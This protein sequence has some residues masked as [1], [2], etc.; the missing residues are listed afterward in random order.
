MRCGFRPRDRDRT[1]ERREVAVKSWRLTIGWSDMADEM[2]ASAG[3]RTCPTARRGKMLG[4]GVEIIR[5]FGRGGHIYR[6]WELG[7]SK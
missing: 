7:E 1:T 2:D 5:E 4:L 3:E 6:F